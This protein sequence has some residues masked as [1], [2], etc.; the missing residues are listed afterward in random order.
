M[1]ED[2]CSIGLAKVPVYYRKPYDGIHVE[3]LESGCKTVSPNLI[4]LRHLGGYVLDDLNVERERGF[5]ME[6]R[7]V[8]VIDPSE[9]RR[10]RG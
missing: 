3:A 1:F 5:G 2:V 7:R 9:Y 4:A 8:R 10:L 6:Y